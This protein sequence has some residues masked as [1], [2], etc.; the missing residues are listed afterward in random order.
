MTFMS[1]RCTMDMRVIKGWWMHCTITEEEGE[2]KE[3]WVKMV[4]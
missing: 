4:K 3:K 1:K 2:K